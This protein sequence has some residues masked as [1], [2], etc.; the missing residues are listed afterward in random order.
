LCGAYIDTCI[1]ATGN[2]FV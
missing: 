1:Q 2:F